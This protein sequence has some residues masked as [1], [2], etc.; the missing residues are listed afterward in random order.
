VQHSWTRVSMIKV[1]SQFVSIHH[2][3]AQ[4]DDLNKDV[5][6]A[7]R[8]AQSK[9]QDRIEEED[10]LNSLQIEFEVLKAESAAAALNLQKAKTDSSVFQREVEEKERQL[11][12]FR[13]RMSAIHDQL[14][15]EKETILSKEKITQHV[16]QRLQAR[17]RELSEV[18]AKNGVLREQMFKDSQHLA[19]LRK[20]EED[21]ISE[22]KSTQVRLAFIVTSLFLLIFFTH[23]LNNHKSSEN[24]QEYKLKA[25]ATRARAHK[26][27]RDGVQ[28]R[29]QVA[30]DGA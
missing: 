24:H 9:R 16:E 20:K 13:S 10:A 26:T 4:I 1:H 29:L 3:Q 6:T 21:L 15:S 28:C 30:A 7:N 17:K 27:T 11:E 14:T 8:A 12:F 25:P 22:I 19:E 23:L 18:Q 5:E 2:Y